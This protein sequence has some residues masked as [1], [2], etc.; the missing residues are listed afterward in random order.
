MNSDRT[1]SSNWPQHV[2]RAG[3]HRRETDDMPNP[4]DHCE[5]VEPWLSA[6]FQA[7]HLNLLVGSGLTTAIASAVGAP[8]VDMQAVSLNHRYAHAVETVAKESAKQLRRGKPNI[9]DQI[10]VIL[11]LIAGLH[12]MAEGAEE[13]RGDHALAREAKE[14]G[15]DGVVSSAQETSLIKNTSRKGA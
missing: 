7:E 12:V 10:R 11:N 15:L 8:T 3:M 9:E 2:L 13:E 4:T 5:H 14:E 1:G 6:L